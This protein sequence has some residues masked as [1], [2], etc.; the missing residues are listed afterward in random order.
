MP[1]E[2]EKN[3]QRVDL[4]T[5]PILGVNISERQFRASEIPSPL[6]PCLHLPTTFCV[7]SLTTVNGLPNPMALTL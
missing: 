1:G 6:H 3:H 5:T 4:G 7:Y 2:F